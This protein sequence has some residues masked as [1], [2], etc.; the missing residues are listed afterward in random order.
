MNS[1]VC[2]LDYMSN[3]RSYYLS[4]FPE[5]DR[6]RRA[7]DGKGGAQGAPG[8]GGNREYDHEEG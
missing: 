6:Q 2:A 3:I 1:A 5:R 7:L 8:V 4:K